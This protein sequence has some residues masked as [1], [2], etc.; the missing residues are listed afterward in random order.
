[1]PR[2]KAA[3]KASDNEASVVPAPDE[4]ELVRYV[5]EKRAQGWTFAL[6]CREGRAG[7]K[8]HFPYEVV[9]RIG[10]GYDAQHGRPTAIIRRLPTEH[11]SG[12]K[13]IPARQLRNE[14]AEIL[15]EVQ[16]GQR[17]LVT[18]SGQEVAEL[19]PLASRY[20]DLYRHRGG[21]PAGITARRGGHFCSLVGR[22]TSRRITRQGS[23]NESATTPDAQPRR[24]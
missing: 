11:P 17:F 19:T 10:K 20:L 12:A 7:D 13:T 2:K 9:H 1:M 22:A 14:S 4:G 24:R 21:P 16:A 3:V 23:C 6:I 8:P 18:I 15:R 5:H